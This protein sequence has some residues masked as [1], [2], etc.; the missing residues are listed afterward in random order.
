MTKLF[1]AINGSVDEINGKINGVSIITIGEALGHGCFID[2]TSLEQVLGLALAQPD[3]VKAKADHG[4]GIFD[5]VGK[6]VNFRRE[7]NQVKADLELFKSDSNFS[8]VLE[9]AIKLPESFGFSVNTSAEYE[10]KDGKKL[11]RF[12]ELESVDLVDAPAANPNGLFSQQTNNNNTMLKQFAVKLGLPETATEAEITAKLDELELAKK[13]LEDKEKDEEKEKLAKKKLEDEDKEKKDKEEMSK[14]E[15]LE[16][17]LSKIETSAVESVQLAEKNAKKASIES[18]IAEASRDGKVIPLT[19]EE[20]M[21]LPID[22][23]KSMFSKLPKGQ[24]KLSA[25]KQST[26]KTPVALKGEE[27]VQFCKAK[28]SEGALQL[29]ELFAS[30]NK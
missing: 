17:R 19:D 5:T 22:S 29:N 12:K 28:K 20:L 25:N 15:A 8:K 14:V 9:M 27:L 16:A 2:S 13:K 4:S 6:L 11:V 24:V 18:L 7:G 10:K 30:L 23:V 1:S 3:G 21:A 26:E